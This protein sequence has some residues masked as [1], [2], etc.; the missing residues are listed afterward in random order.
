MIA[1]RSH[2]L[3][4]ADTGPQ[5]FVPSNLCTSFRCITQTCTRTW[6]GCC[7]DNEL[8]EIRIGSQMWHHD[9]LA[10]AEMGAAPCLNEGLL[11]VSVCEGDSSATVRD[12]WLVR[13]CN[14]DMLCSGTYRQHHAE[15]QQ[16]ARAEQNCQ[17]MHSQTGLQYCALSDR[18]TTCML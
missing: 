12:G 15:L 11:I 6:I 9:V 8:T 7:R 10:G 5:A 3:H 13:C 14:S 4:I 17:S 16:H 2:R 1:P 18:S